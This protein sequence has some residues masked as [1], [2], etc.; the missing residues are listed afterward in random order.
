MSEEQLNI[1]QNQIPKH[2][3]IIMDG[4]GRWAKRRGALRLMGH[5]S[6]A[7]SV[8]EV[9]EACA[10]LGVEYLTVYAFSS[11]N[12]NRPKQEINGL[13]ELLVESLEKEFNTL[14]NNGIRLNAI[15]DLQKLPEKVRLKLQNTIKKTNDGQ[16]MCLNLALSYS[17]QWDI[18]QATRQI[19]EDSING[20]ISG[21]D[22]IDEVLFSQ[23]LSTKDMPMP[24]LVIRTSGE[25]RLSNF[26][27][28]QMA[29]SELYFTNTLWPDFGKNELI[30][31]I[32]DY[33]LRERRYG[34]TSE[35]IQ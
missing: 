24:D 30:K 26:L 6:G 34:K 23:Y 2:I 19:V 9:T 12:W 1:N 29:Y 4:N 35:Q 16:R 3:A 33:Q 31:A 15:G 22:Q 11:E 17:G 5:R 7:K 25:F 20:K 14:K 32:L 27:L 8:R 18:V 21:I 13:M 10:E 28:F